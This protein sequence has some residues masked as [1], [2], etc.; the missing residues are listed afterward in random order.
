MVPFRLAP[1]GP[2]ESLKPPLKEP[3]FLHGLAAVFTAI[4]GGADI[5]LQTTKGSEI[6]IHSWAHIV[7]CTANPWN[8]EMAAACGHR[9]DA[10][11][12]WGQRH[13][14]QVRS[15]SLLIVCWLHANLVCPSLQPLDVVG[16]RQGLFGTVL[17]HCPRKH[18][19]TVSHVRYNSMFQVSI[20]A[21]RSNSSNSFADFSKLACLA[22]HE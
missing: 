18:V 1:R 22:A 6:F 15:A 7:I 20:G 3:D 9:E 11:P 4:L 16:M 13:A 5:W 2:C 19:V 10:F 12:D 17:S 8:I 14:T 21:E